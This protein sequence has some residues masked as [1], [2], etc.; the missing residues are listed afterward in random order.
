MIEERTGGGS[1]AEAGS[2]E[3]AEDSPRILNVSRQ[4]VVTEPFPHVIKEGMIEVDFYRRLKAEFPSDKLFDGRGKKIGARTGRDF[5]QGDAGFDEFLAQSPTWRAFHAYMHSPRFLQ[6]TLDLF[7]EHLERFGCR[8]DPARARLVDFTEN[9]FRV[10]WRARKARWFGAGGQK[11]PNDLFVRFDIEQGTTGY[12]KPVH[13]DNPSRL[14]SLL[15][16]FCDAD[17]IGMEGG[18]LR[19][20]EH[21]QKKPYTEYERHPKPEDTRIVA[22]YR[23]RENFGAFFLCSNNS[24]HSVTAVTAVKDYRRFIYMNLSSTADS[25]W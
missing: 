13:C 1:A 8:V 25:I 12:A 4:E 10:W 14:V 21:L 15:V 22:S 9:R 23:P 7:G 3:A 6:L 24:Y 5:Y 20:H 18:D 17:E 11:D 19:I 16:Y 2:V